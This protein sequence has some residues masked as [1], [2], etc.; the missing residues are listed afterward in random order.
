MVSFWIINARLSTSFSLSPAY[1]TSS[2]PSR[3]ILKL[4]KPKDTHSLIMHHPPVFN[5]ALGH[6]SEWRFVFSIF[7]SPWQWI[8]TPGWRTGHPP[9]SW[10]SYQKLTSFPNPP[11]VF[12]SSNKYPWI[13]QTKYPTNRSPSSSS[14]H[15]G[16]GHLLQVGGQVLRLRLSLYHQWE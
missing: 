1:L 7:S 16:L 5:L 9:P 12:P 10:S 3:Y 13:D 14:L 15:L 6:G 11:T 4:I 8:A 2:F